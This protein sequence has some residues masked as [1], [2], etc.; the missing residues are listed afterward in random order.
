M[1]GGWCEDIMTNGGDSSNTTQPGSTSP[2]SK[3]EPGPDVP[4]QR[5]GIDDDP[6]ATGVSDFSLAAL[7]RTWLSTSE[8]VERQARPEGDDSPPRPTWTPPP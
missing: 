4:E 1:S 2:G 6:V 5:A 3:P 8:A 7:V